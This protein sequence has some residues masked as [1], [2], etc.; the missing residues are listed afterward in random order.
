MVENRRSAMVRFC[1]AAGAALLAICSPPRSPLEQVADAV[2]DVGIRPCLPRLT[3]LPYGRSSSAFRIKAARAI[4][5]CT[6]SPDARTRGIGLLLAGRAADGAALLEKAH[7]WS[8]LAA[9]RYV[10]AAELG[11]AR[12]MVR[13]LA[14]ADR[15]LQMQPQSQ[16]ALFNRSLALQWLGF[17]HAAEVAR[18]RY[19]QIDGGSQWADELRRRTPPRTLPT[20]E[21][22]KAALARVEM[23]GGDELVAAMVR[24]F[25]RQARSWAEVELLGRWGE[26][27]LA[28]DANAPRDL[29]LARSIGHTLTAAT[30]EQLLLDEMRTI[31]GRGNAQRAFAEAHAAYRRG[32]LLYARRDVNAAANAI[33]KAR[34]MFAELRSPMALVADYYMANIRID[35]NE[36]EQGIAMLY[37]LLARTPIRYAALRAQCNWTLGYALGKSGRLIEAYEQLGAAVGTFDRLGE[38]DNAAKARSL[39][40]EIHSAF[41]RPLEAWRMRRPLFAGLS[42]SGDMRGLQDAA[43]AAAADEWEAGA[44]DTARS[45]LSL[46]LE[47]PDPGTPRL[48]T[49][50][51]LRRAYASIRLGDTRDAAADLAAARNEENAIADAALKASAESDRKYIEALLDSDPA[52]F[53]EAIEFAKTHHFGLNVPSMLRDRA[54]A[55]T[56]RGRT[57][58][59]I[60]DLE[61]SF[62]MLDELR[63]TIGPDE[64]RDTFFSTADSTVEDLAALL[65]RAGENDRLVDLLERSRGRGIVDRLAGTAADA[66][67]VAELRRRMPADAVLLHYLCLEDRIVIAAIRH[68][69][70]QTFAVSRRRADVEA[71]IGSLRAAIAGSDDQHARTIGERL[72]GDLI[73]PAEAAIGGARQLAISPDAALS[74]LPFPAL[75]D[76]R[77]YLV[78]RFPIT[79]TPSATAYLARRTSE[80]RQP[81]ALIV[82]D[83]RFD[84][85]IF[86]ALG[87]LPETAVE[88]RSIAGL[89]RDA[90][91]ATGE[92]AT[93]S[94]LLRNAPASDVI[95]IA[96]H[97]V[98]NERDPAASALVLASD[99]GTPGLVYLR[100]VA[101]LS[102]SRAPVVVLSGCRSGLATPGAGS[103]R[104]FAVAFLAAGARGA[105][106]T[107]WDVEDSIARRASTELHRALPGRTP[108]QSLREVQLRAIRAGLPLR[109]WSAFQLFGSYEKEGKG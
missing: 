36:P 98:I 55:L 72:H 77:R 99:G 46:A 66:L 51:H 88:A 50:F 21:R 44:W 91:V 6:A 8:D 105:V 1:V 70:T 40:A 12:E 31:D 76:G 61:Q 71:D 58:D 60:T 69:A 86:P 53:T 49:D 67:P 24:D 56:K 10:V 59:A 45:L 62:R 85:T 26:A 101:R 74:L 37:A 64:L 48:R 94:A 4:D 17:A 102:L 5:A 27:F 29:A 42:A 95:H 109:A 20:S 23:T 9:A 79:I 103:I 33:E 7:A 108:A 80:A 14:A 84:A 52:L 18:R 16:E 107:L 30:G 68:D 34:S 15:A 89:Y 32:R 63:R 75:Y 104:S 100:D 43:G 38:S 22:W 93:P 57:G 41:G 65:L 83:P 25:P 78:E 13:A 87:P 90:N 3:A 96:S 39:L 2:R 35:R 11:D 73:A 82:A 92:R 19:L 106:G 47:S 54:R 97:V 81:H 28:G